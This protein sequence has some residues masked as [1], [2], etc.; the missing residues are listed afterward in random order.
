M[1]PVVTRIAQG[2]HGPESITGTVFRTW[3]DANRNYVPDCDLKSPLL[4]GECGP[5]ANDKFGTPVITLRYD[6]EYLTGWGKRDYNWQGSVS[7]QQELAPRIALNVGYFRTWYGNFTVT[8]NLAVTS[9]DY[10]PFC[11]TAPVD[12]RLPGG[13]GNRICDLY[14]IN[15]AKF[16]KVDNMVTPVAP[17]GERTEVFNG[18]DFA[19]N[20]R[21]N[22]GGMVSGGVSIGQ[23]AV[24]NCV[25]VDSPQQQFC[26]NTS[27]Q[28][29]V[30]WSI[31]YP[32]PWWGLQ[33]SAL[34]QNLPGINITSSY[35]ASD[36]QIAPSL[37]RNL[38]AC[39]TQVVCNATATIELIEPNSL[40]EPRQNQL[41]V[42][43]SKIIRVGRALNTVKVRR[44]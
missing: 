39:G 29:Q 44:L 6:P 4:N 19:I 7:V 35:V 24:N 32:L 37:G 26:N 15:P 3:I 9:T 43:L 30:K 18:A 14:D 42:R 33:A 40:R 21:F 41:D 34:F 22:N 13:G 20:A 17:F 12:P 16:G 38:A 23:T 10:D 27:S 31:V 2:S 1:H 25:V 5:M 11:I 8:D 36:A 28:N